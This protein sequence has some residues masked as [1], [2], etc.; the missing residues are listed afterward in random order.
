MNL[1]DKI[2]D[3]VNDDKIFDQ[4]SHFFGQKKSL[5]YSHLC[6]YIKMSFKMNMIPKIGIL[7]K[8][9]PKR[10]RLSILDPV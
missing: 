4:L 9:I 8:N 6:A 2:N 10:L 3:Q 5:K 7:Y 1:Q